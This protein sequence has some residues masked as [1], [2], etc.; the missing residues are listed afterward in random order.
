MLS[1]WPFP[2]VLCA[3]LM[4]MGRGGA[5]G[6]PPSVLGSVPGTAQHPLCGEG[7]GTGVGMCRWGAHSS[8]QGPAPQGITH[9]GKTGHGKQGMGMCELTQAAC[10]TCSKRRLAGMRNSSRQQSPSPR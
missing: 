10:R 8:G 1:L 4:L 7:T 9:E 2:G 6:A 3:P 5:G